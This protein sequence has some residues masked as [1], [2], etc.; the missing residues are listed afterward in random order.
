MLKKNLDILQRRF[1][2]VLQ[3]ILAVGEKK[4]SQLYYDDASRLLAIRPKG[5]FPVYGTRAKERLIEDW[6]GA[7]RLKNE[8]LYSLSGFGDG[9]HVRHFL[10]NTSGGIF[11]LIMEVDAAILKETFSRHDCSDILRHERFLLGTG[12]INE[13]FF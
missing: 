12:Q 13:D 9:S 3:R 11:L 5:D 10:K 6:F 1:P 4:P 7:L 2:Q 8:S